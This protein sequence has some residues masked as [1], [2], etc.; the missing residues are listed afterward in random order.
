M[1][2]STPLDVDLA[3]A[4]TLVTAAFNGTMLPHY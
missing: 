2:F 1:S 4:A 3:Y